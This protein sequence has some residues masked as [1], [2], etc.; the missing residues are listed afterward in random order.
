MQPP[1]RV[2]KNRSKNK[3]KNPP[4]ATISYRE[5]LELL[6]MPM[7]NMDKSSKTSIYTAKLEYLFSS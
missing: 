3:N 6:N 7:T 4:P 5:L 1:E 2:R